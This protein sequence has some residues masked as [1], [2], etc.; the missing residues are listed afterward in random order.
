MMVRLAKQPGGS[1]RVLR[2]AKE[3]ECCV[4]DHDRLKQSFHMEA[5]PNLLVG[6]LQIGCGGWI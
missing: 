6:T 4:R 3:E 5:L 1:A 2:S